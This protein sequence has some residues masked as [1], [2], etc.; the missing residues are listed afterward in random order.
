MV[1]SQVALPAFARY[2][3]MLV[4]IAPFLQTKKT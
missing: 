1:G 4:A 3:A 2:I